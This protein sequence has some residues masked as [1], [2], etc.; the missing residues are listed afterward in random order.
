MPIDGMRFTYISPGYF[1]LPEVELVSQC[2]PDRCCCICCCLCDSGAR[3]LAPQV[4][5]GQRLA[6]GVG[7]GAAAADSGAV[8]QP[9]SEPASGAWEFLWYPLLPRLAFN[10][11][12]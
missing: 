12:A 7:T 6:P 11:M 8:S 1:Q 10:G 5:L 3:A 9:D 2:A 4:R